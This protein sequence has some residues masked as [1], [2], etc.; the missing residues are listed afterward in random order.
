MIQEPILIVDDEVEVRSA[1]LEALTSHGYSA[2]AVASGE[3]ALVRMA[4]RRFPVVLTDFHMPGGQSGLDLINEVRLRFPDTL[5]IL[6]TAYA[7]LDTS[8][9]ALK[10]GAYDLVQKP[11][12]LAEV[13]VV[14][15]RA[16]DHAALLQKVHLYQAELEDRILSRTRALQEAHQEALALCDLSL[17]SLEAPGLLEALD[18]LLAWLAARWRPAGIGCYRRGGNGDLMRLA[19]RGPLPLP[20]TLDRPLPGPL[21]AP[22]L[23][24]AENHFL[25]LGNAGWLYLGFAERSA[26]SE[27][28]PAFLLLARHLELLLRVR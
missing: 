26:F 28:D 14:L 16:L 20:A 19:A 13:E 9:E 12:R 11:F 17:Q 27:I 23:G 7:T 10:R 21:K 4:E 24:Y 18:P 5:C 8:I 1:L 25:P 6:I 15:D 2:E 3:A 22:D